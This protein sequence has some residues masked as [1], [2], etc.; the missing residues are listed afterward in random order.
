ME[1]KC[2]SICA[3]SGGGGMEM[4]MNKNIIIFG[5]GTSGLQAYLRLKD[6]YSIPYFADNAPEKIGT[7]FCDIPVIHPKEIKQKAD[8]YKVVI[9]SIYFEEIAN[10]LLQN[11][12]Y[13]IEAFETFVTNVA[14]TQVMC[15][16]QSNS[17]EKEYI[18]TILN[19]PTYKDLYYAELPQKSYIREETDPKVI[20]YYLPQFHPTEENDKWWGKGVTE[21]NNVMRAV[22]QYVG[23]YQPKIPGELGWYDLRLKENIKR[24]I[25]LAKWNGIYGFCYYYYNFGGKRLLDKPLD[26]LLDDKSLSMPFCLCWANENWTAGF[27]GTRNNILIEQKQDVEEYK[28]VIYDMQKYMSDMRY[29]E[30]QGRKLLVIYRPSFIPDTKKVLQYWRKSCQDAGIGDIYIVGIKEMHYDVDLLGLGFDAQAEFQP[31]NVKPYAKD[32]SK[33]MKYVDS[34][35]LGTIYDYEDIVI[36]KKYKKLTL[37]KLY[38]SIIPMWDNSARKNNKGLIF[39]R[40]TPALYK[41]WLKDILMESKTKDLDEPAVFINAWNEWGE[42]TYLEPDKRYGYAYLKA[43][44]EALEEI[45]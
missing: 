36:N 30:I 31:N 41:T 7:K 29:I 2:A 44:K 13:N 32:I 21:W 16:Q 38:R 26:M 35:F 12:V 14:Q 43:T 10:Q 24:Q 33:E 22:P 28:N 15:A 40:S 18:K 6:F 9:A 20:A 17:F 3:A 42:G 19:T 4:S 5:C 45:R 11:Q 8:I 1:V 39:E 37:E 25:E 27:D 23:H 34:N